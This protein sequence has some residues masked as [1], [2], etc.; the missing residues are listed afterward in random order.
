MSDHKMICCKVLCGESCLQSKDI[1][2]TNWPLKSDETGCLYDS[3]V[4]D[5][6]K[7]NIYYIHD[8]ARVYPMFVIHHE[9]R[10]RKYYPSMSSGI[11]GSW[12]YDSPC[13]T[14]C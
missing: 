5:I 2:L 1:K 4:D 13:E 3:L 7:P 11:Y 14:F 10:R 6:V 8:D 9:K 12:L